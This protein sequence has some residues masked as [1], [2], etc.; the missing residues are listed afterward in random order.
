MPLRETP[1]SGR[2]QKQCSGTLTVLSIGGWDRKRWSFWGLAGLD[3][4]SG[5]WE[6]VV[7]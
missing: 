1:G 6:V 5:L 4:H 7:I 2:R 3:H